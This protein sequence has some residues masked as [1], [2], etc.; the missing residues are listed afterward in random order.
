[1]SVRVLLW[2]ALLTCALD[3]QN[4]GPLELATA[5]VPTGARRVA[6]GRDPLQFGELRLPGTQGPHPVAILVHG[7]C[8][9]A[10]VGNLDERG[11]QEVARD[12]TASVFLLRLIVAFTTSGRAQKPTDR[13][14]ASGTYNKS[15]P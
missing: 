3:A 5:P 13:M 8:W 1:M 2:L 9:R 6:Y 7:G 12:E 11:I 4:R 14:Y 10:R 15:I